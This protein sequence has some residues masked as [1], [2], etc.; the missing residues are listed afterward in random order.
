MCGHTFAVAYTVPSFSTAIRMSCPAAKVGE[1][2][3]GFRS[4]VELTCTQAF[5]TGT[6]SPF[7]DTAD[8]RT[9]L[10][11]GPWKASERATKLASIVMRLCRVR[12][13]TTRGLDLAATI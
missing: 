10:V 11:A 9:A 7:I 2:E 13:T 3:F 12:L 8:E 4:E 1:S 6:F 5:F